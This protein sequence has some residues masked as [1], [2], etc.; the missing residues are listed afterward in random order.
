M[1]S[2]T[3]IETI[4]AYLIWM[5]K[6]HSVAE[7]VYVAQSGIDVK[8]EISVIIRRIFVYFLGQNSPVHSLQELIENPNLKFITPINTFH[9]H[10]R[11]VFVNI[12]LLKLKLQK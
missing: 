12:F 7:M 11:Y 10:N 4:N 2:M 3:W 9:G 5:A 8:P 6:I 1:D